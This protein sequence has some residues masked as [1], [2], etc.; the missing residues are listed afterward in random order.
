MI[1]P[2]L[3]MFYSIVALILFVGGYVLG[4]YD[5]TPPTTVQQAQ[6]QV[7]SVRVMVEHI[8]TLVRS[9]DRILRHTDTTYQQVR[10]TL[11]KA[12][13][14]TTVVERFV[15]ACDSL[16]ASCDAYRTAAQ[17]KF[18]ADSQLFAAQTQAIAAWRALQ[19]PRVGITVDGG[20]SFTTKHPIGHGEITYGL[21]DRLKAVGVIAI[22]DNSNIMRA[23]QSLLLRYTFH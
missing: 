16:K 4:R 15:Q 13:H 23:K 9:R 10:D 22:T 11:L 1:L 6:H 19:P 14:D 5:R 2:R 18:L 8:D 12:I 3:W 20:Y 17:A 21:S 7:D